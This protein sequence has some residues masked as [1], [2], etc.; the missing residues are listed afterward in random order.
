MKS[1]LTMLLVA[2]LTIV[3]LA[4]MACAPGAP[5][6]DQG[7]GTPG[8]DSSSETE[9]SAPGDEVFNWRMTTQGPAV[10]IWHYG[11]EY[12]ADIVNDMSDGRLQITLHPGGSLFPVPDTLDNVTQGV[13]EMAQCGGVAFAGKDPTFTA[14]SF[15]TGASIDN[16]MDEAVYVWHTDYKDI[17]SDLYAK[18]GCKWLAPGWIPGEQYVSR[19]PIRSADDYKGLKIRASGM[20]EL[21]FQELGASTTYVQGSEIYSALQLGTIDGCDAA[22]AA[23]NWDTGLH[24]VTDYII[25]PGFHLNM[26]H[27]DHFV[28]QDAWNSLPPDL[29]HILQVAAIA[30]G[31]H[32]GTE[33]H[34][35]NL[36][37]EQNMIDYGLEV[38]TL[39]DEEL[40][41]IH[42][43]A[44]RVWDDV[45]A[46]TPEAARLIGIYEETCALVGKPMR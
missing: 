40:E 14:V 18:H 41:K 27:I 13:V 1:K 22:G 39:P 30:G 46:S 34:A 29:Q 6:N 42:Q 36:I 2:A 24:E 32:F 7:G 16:T 38:I 37:A 4:A 15:V 26:G 9:T 43:A 12:F 19:V 20:S 33:I 45:A 11:N 17:V 21:L 23:G 5:A 35:K 10:S 8:E 25:K 28:N 3:S 44:V 31:D